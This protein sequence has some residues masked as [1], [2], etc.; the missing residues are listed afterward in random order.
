MKVLS[1]KYPNMTWGKMEAVINKLGGIKGVESFLADMVA[2]TQCHLK[3]WRNIRLGT[4]LKTF[5]DFRKAF[6]KEG[7][8]IN[9]WT[10]EILSNFLFVGSIEEK[11]IELVAISPA[12]L[13]FKDGAR[14]GDIYSRA[15]ERGLGLCT[16]E[17]AL[18]LRRQYK[19]QPKEIGR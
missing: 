6:R 16:V 4:G 2:K 9:K 3:T 18:E 10:K 8:G 5:N 13:G 19:N 12:E 1:M 7:Y 17:T 11:E 15:E 14:L